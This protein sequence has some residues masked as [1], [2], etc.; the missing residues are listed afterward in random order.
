[1]VHTPDPMSETI[2]SRPTTAILKVI[3][4]F[5]TLGS[6]GHSSKSETS[7]VLSIKEPLEDK[8]NYGSYSAN[9]LQSKLNK[10]LKIENKLRSH[11]K[12]LVVDLLNWAK[13]VPSESCESVIK[14]FANLYSVKGFAAASTMD[15]LFKIKS[16]LAS[17]EQREKKTRESCETNIKL[18]KELKD[19][20]SKFGSGS[21]RSQMIREKIESNSINLETAEMQ[22]VRSISTELKEALFEYVLSLQD[23]SKRIDNATTDYSMNIV[24]TEIDNSSGPKSKLLHMARKEL[25]IPS[26]IPKPISEGN[27]MY[28][29]RNCNFKGHNK[30]THL[31][32]EFGYSL[33]VECQKNRASNTN[34]ANTQNSNIPYE[35]SVESGQKVNEINNPSRIPADDIK[36]TY[37]YRDGSFNNNNDQWN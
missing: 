33:C 28:V 6:R 10:I 14:N 7:S 25:G 1:M 4:K 22:F 8:P 13:T 3:D 18:L 20:E 32:D 5:S 37:H 19:Y 12:D 15:N 27:R 17:V 11:E 36:Q 9:K 31:I 23:L 21:N 34:S 30:E 26:T 29:M 16:S 35:S 24:N 2:L